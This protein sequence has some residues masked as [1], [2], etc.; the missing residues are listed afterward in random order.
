[1]KLLHYEQN[2]ALTLVNLHCSIL[3]QKLLM[4]MM[5]ITKNKKNNKKN[6][7]KTKTDTE[8]S[9]FISFTISSLCHKP[10]PSRMQCGQ[11]AIMRKSHAIHQVQ[12]TCYALCKDTANILILTELELQDL[13]LIL[14]HW[15]KSFTDKGGSETRAPEESC[16]QWTL[17]YVTCQSPQIQ[18]PTKAR[19]HTPTTVSG[20]CWKSKCANLLHTAHRL[21]YSRAIP[22]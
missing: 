14:N 21:F 18:A 4:T 5:M 12:T 20:T 8:K 9:S 16:W 19:T 1:M 6:K 3:R 17:E 11:N 13:F 7:K 22:R 15:L 2:I 10:S